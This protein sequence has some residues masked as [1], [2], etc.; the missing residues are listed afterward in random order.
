MK[1]FRPRLRDVSHTKVCYSKETYCG[2][3]SQSGIHNFGNGEIAVIHNHASCVYGEVEDVSHGVYFREGVFLLQRSYDHGETWRREDDIVLWNN[4]WPEEKKKAIHESAVE[5]GVQREEIDL[6]SED[7]ITFFKRSGSEGV[8]SRGNMNHETHVFRSADRGHSWEEVP[9]R[10]APPQ[11]YSSVLVDGYPPVYFDDGTLGVMADLD[12][13]QLGFYAT[14]DNGVEWGFFAMAALEPIEAVGRFAYPRMLRLPGGRLQCYMLN[15]AGMRRNVLTMI[16]SDD[17]GF[18]WSEPRVIVS[19][20]ESPWAKLTR[21][22]VWSG[23]IPGPLYRSPWPVLL[24]DGRIVVIFA[25]RRPPYGMGLILS[26]DE[27]DSWSGEAV[28]R[29]DGSD[30]DIGYPVATE[31]ED[32]R[33]FTAYYYMEDDGNKF[34]G[35]RYIA[36]SAFAV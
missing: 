5:P 22:H 19:W 1:G 11:G 12:Q 24:R 14:E 36:G 26:E 13:S 9:T 6:G 17:G 34:G 8:D 15:L 20:G 32:G 33:I 35:T 28:I 2:H 21:D 29:A 4:G 30:W 10:L 23:A 27:G 31:L 7:A 18:T 16:H 25:R 3:P